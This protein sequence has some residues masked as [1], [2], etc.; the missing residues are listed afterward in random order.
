VLRVAQLPADYKD[1][2]VTTLVPVDDGV[3]KVLKWVSTTGFVRWCPYAGKPDQQLDNSFK[4]LQEAVREL[5][6]TFSTIELGGL[7]KIELRAAMEAVRHPRLA[8]MRARASGP[9]TSKDG[10]ASASA[11]RLAANW[12]HRVSRSRSASRLPITWSR[13]RARSAAGSCRTCWARNSTG[14][15]MGFLRDFRP[16]AC[17]N[18]GADL[19]QRLGC[20]A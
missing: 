20:D 13:S 10:S 5:C 9:G 18:Y 3:R 15:D 11:S 2:D 1:S 16:I 4:L 7:K 12:F 17:H 6:A 8:L 19:G 14:T